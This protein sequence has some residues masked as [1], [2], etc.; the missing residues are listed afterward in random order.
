M[1]VPCGAAG[2][3]EAWGFRSAPGRVS[4]T[5]MWP[6]QSC[7]TLRSGRCLAWCSVVPS[8]HLFSTKIRH[9]RKVKQPRNPILAY[10]FL[11]LANCVLSCI[12]FF[13]TPWSV[14]LQVPLSMEFSRLEY[15]NEL[16][17]PSSG[18]LPDWGVAPATQER[19]KTLL[20]ESPALSC[21]FFTAAPPGKP[22]LANYLHHSLWRWRK[23]R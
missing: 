17:F 8:W 18:D 20:I 3:R 5:S 11:T 10:Q 15:R 4:F 16:P 14:A 6:M 7:R 9:F 13:T 21:R 22:L 19:L 12:W 23:W 1:S 2:K